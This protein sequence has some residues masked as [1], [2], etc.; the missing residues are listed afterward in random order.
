MNH[1]PE[2]HSTPDTPDE[3]TA[4]AHDH[5]PDPHAAHAAPAHDHA[6]D[7]HAAHAAPATHDHAPDPHAAH[8]A[9]SHDHA[10]DPH[11]AHS[12]DQSEEDWLM[13]ENDPV[14]EVSL[15]KTPLYIIRN[16]V[17]GSIGN[18]LRRG[19][20]IVTPAKD[21]LKSAWN[22]F[23]NPFKNP[24]NTLR[25]PLKYLANLPRIGTATT[26]ATKNL[27]KAPITAT[28]EGY[29]DIVQAPL[30]RID[31][32]IAKIPPR[33]VTG[34]V[35]RFNNGVANVMGWPLRFA[36]KIAKGA[37]NWIDDVDAYFGAAIQGV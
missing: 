8:A 23:K 18:A 6:P 24:L 10:P 34:M 9:P 32:K 22:L 26:K 4:P 19:K 31:Y 20:E 28:N 5:A 17:R 2:H 7:P 30:Q 1:G 11:A 35:A 29:Q 3:H 13:G 16:W 37:T 27:A 33:T 12:H 25:H 21:A 15:P 36:D 14:Q